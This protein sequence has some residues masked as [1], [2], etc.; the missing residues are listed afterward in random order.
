MASLG[1]SVSNNELGEYS[2]PITAPLLSKFRQSFAKQPVTARLY[3]PSGNNI[4]DIYK[5]QILVSEETR[6]ISIQVQKGITEGE[7]DYYKNIDLIHPSSSAPAYDPCYLTLDNANIISIL[8]DPRGDKADPCTTVSIPELKPMMNFINRPWTNGQAKPLAVKIVGA[9]E[10]LLFFMINPKITL[11]HTEDRTLIVL[12]AMN[13]LT[14]YKFSY[15]Q[16][17]AISHTHVSCLNSTTHRAYDPCWHDSHHKCKPCLPQE[18]I[19]KHVIKTKSTATTNLSTPSTPQ[20]SLYPTEE[21]I[22]TSTDIALN[23]TIQPQNK[24]CSANTF[25]IAV[26]LLQ[27]MCVY[28]TND[29]SSCAS[30]SDNYLLIDCNATELEPHLK[31]KDNSLEE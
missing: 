31:D 13:I 6:T 21:Q 9:N 17:G 4:A 30:I 14:T 19:P 7:P 29:R 10:Y 24:V 26:L 11:V 12:Q 5:F 23:T 15:I 1:R 16:Q 8:S 27:L 28:Y 18:E 20:N 3:G 2:P 25:P 22:T